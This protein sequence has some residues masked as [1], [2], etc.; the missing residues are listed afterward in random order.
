M[1]IVLNGN[2]HNF[3][4]PVWAGCFKIN[5]LLKLHAQALMQI[6]AISRICT[7]P[8]VLGP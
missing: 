6:L 7:G 1:I 3:H 8:A 2:S 5:Y 4:M